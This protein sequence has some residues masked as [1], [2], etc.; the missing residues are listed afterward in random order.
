[1]RVIHASTASSRACTRETARVVR[2]FPSRLIRRSLRVSQVA[3]V[4]ASVCARRKALA[5]TDAMLYGDV[6]QVSSGNWRRKSGPV[7]FD[8]PA[9][10]F[11]T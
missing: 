1:M 4:H 3:R 7:Y 10:M 8:F 9:S 2:P 5:K 11:F 6:S